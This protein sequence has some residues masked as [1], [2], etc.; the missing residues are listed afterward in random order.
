MNHHG[1]ERSASMEYVA[2]NLL[3]RAALLVRLLVKQVPTGEISR[4]EVE[5]LAELAQGTRRITE[6]AELEGLAQPT[7]T[8]LVRRLEA[9]GWIVREGLPD[10]GR[11]VIV[12]ITH[13]GRA[14]VEGFRAQ[15]LA[16]L[17][18]DLEVLSDSDLAELSRATDAL[19][20]FVDVLQAVPSARGSR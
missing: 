3:A 20:S 17:T 1:S 18:S 11:V 7:M 14:A 2:G 4:T 12:A 10:D 6:L 16:A 9:R 8:V 15:F 5:V 19:G 13:E